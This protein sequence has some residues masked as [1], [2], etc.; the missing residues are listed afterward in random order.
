MTFKQKVEKILNE[1]RPQLQADGGDIELIEADEEKGLV[2]VKLA[3]RCQFCPMAAITLEKV[4]EK[5][6]K[7]EIPEVKEVINVMLQK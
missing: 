3:G 4:V 1:I 6:L 2:T 5:K 7:D